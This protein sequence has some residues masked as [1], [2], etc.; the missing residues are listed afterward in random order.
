MTAVNHAASSPL[1]HSRLHASALHLHAPSNATMQGPV[2]HQHNPRRQPSGV[3]AAGT[4]ESPGAVAE[5]HI[6][7]R[8]AAPSITA[9]FALSSSSS[10]AAAAAQLMQEPSW[11]LSLATLRRPASAVATAR[12]SASDDGGK[13]AGAVAHSHHSGHAEAASFHYSAFSWNRVR[14]NV[15]LSRFCAAW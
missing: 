8:P 1:R 10:S 11:R 6:K 12:R 2:R 7:M 4:T 5:E 9:P 3:V 14:S 15:V 13:A